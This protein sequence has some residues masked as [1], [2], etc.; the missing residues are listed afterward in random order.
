MEEVDAHRRLGGSAWAWG[1]RRPHPHRRWL[2]ANLR[3]QDGAAG[4]QRQRSADPFASLDGTRVI[5][6][7]YPL[8]WCSMSR[9]GQGHGQLSNCLQALL[10]LGQT[11]FLLFRSISLRPPG[12]GAWRPVTMYMPCRYKPGLHAVSQKGQ[13]FQGLLKWAVNGGV[14]P[15]HLS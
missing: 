14:P 11:A 3:D 13:A 15:P 12:R 7:P 10:A 9:P 5:A 2:F 1:R 6:T 8:C 4:S